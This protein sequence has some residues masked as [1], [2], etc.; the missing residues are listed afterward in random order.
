MKLKSHILFWSFA[1][2]VGAMIYYFPQGTW[3]ALMVVGV[4]VYVGRI[5]LARRKKPQTEPKKKERVCCPRCSGEEP[6]P[7]D[8][9]SR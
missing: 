8:K 1:V 2:F 3:L 4:V 6:W 9:R 7:G 5:I